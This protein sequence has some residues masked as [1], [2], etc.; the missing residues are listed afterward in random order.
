MSVYSNFLLPPIQSY[1]LDPQKFFS[2]NS[3][4]YALITAFAIAILSAIVAVYYIVKNCAPSVLEKFKRTETLSESIAKIDAFIAEDKKV[5]LFVGRTPAEELPP[6]TGEAKPDEVWVSG[7]IRDDVPSI[8]KE[9]VHLCLD[10]N[11]DDRLNM[12]REKFDLIV[13]DASVIKF[14]DNDFAKRFAV[15]LRS[16]ESELIFE[17]SIGY[18]GIIDD[19]KSKIVFDNQ[20]YAV[21]VSTAHL[22]QYYSNL[23]RRFREYKKNSSKEEEQADWENF[24]TDWGIDEIPVS[25]P[26]PLPKE[27]ERDFWHFIADKEG[28]GDDENMSFGFTQLESHLKT[29]FD[30]VEFHKNDPYPYLNYY[31]THWPF[32]IVGKPKGECIQQQA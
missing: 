4:K 2:A 25:L 19:P 12:L 1:L 18:R 10:F 9:R 11:D 23:I 32:F 28:F 3:K 26:D 30:R 13:V 27:V 8:N 31:G 20:S 7:D 21:F 17:G 5:C 29:I 15:M 16:P 6:E 22:T 24:I 14:F